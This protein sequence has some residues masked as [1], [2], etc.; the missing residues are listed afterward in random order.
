MAVADAEA[1]GKAGAESDVAAAV[2]AAADVS[3]GR[4]FDLLASYS[5]AVVLSGSISNSSN[6]SASSLATSPSKTLSRIN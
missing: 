2:A 3:G 6:F 1:S 4:D 5:A